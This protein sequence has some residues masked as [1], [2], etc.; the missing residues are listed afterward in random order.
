MIT[1][2][3]EWLNTPAGLVVMGLVV[4]VVVGMAGASVWRSFGNSA[5]GDASRQRWF[6]CADTNQ[7]F[8]ATLELDMEIPLMSPYSHANTGYPAELNYWAADGSILTEPIPVLLNTYKG[9]N[10]PTFCPVTGRLVVAN[11]PPAI[12]GATPPPTREEYS[13]RRRLAA[14]ER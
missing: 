5:A 7:A 12:E 8:Q 9:D 1:R 4:V 6:V 3:R 13:S 11:N 10:S 2:I 14:G